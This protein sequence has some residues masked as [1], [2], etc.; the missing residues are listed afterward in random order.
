MNA[1]FVWI[2]PHRKIAATYEVK[3]EFNGSNGQQFDTMI[4]KPQLNTPLRPGIWRLVVL[5]KLDIIVETK[6]LVSPLLF[7]NATAIEPRRAHSI[8]NGSEQT[9]LAQR[10]SLSN[11]MLS[12]ALSLANLS[13]G[14]ED[15]ANQPL[16]DWVD[17]LYSQFWYSS[18]MCYISESTTF[19]LDFDCDVDLSPCHLSDWSSCSPDPKSDISTLL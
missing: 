18:Q 4:Q 10:V 8:H 5:D 2:D 9:Y 3:V 6:F 14:N 16:T 12:N 7:F 11:N 15:N 19:G 13:P 1:T 17:Q